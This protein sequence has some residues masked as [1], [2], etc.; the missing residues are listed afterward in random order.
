MS[1]NNQYREEK[2]EMMGD[3]YQQQD[4]TPQDTKSFIGR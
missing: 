3:H 4:T 1:I 2:Q